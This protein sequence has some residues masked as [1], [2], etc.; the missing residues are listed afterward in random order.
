MSAPPNAGRPADGPESGPTTRGTAEHLLAGL[1]RALRRHP[2]SRVLASATYRLAARIGGVRLGSLESG[3]ALWLDLGDYVQ[4]HIYMW[5]TFEEAATRYLRHHAESSWTFIDVG[6]CEGYYAVLAVALGG[7]GS[8]V[9]AVEPNPGMAARLRDTVRRGGYPIEL[10]EVGCGAAPGV[11]PLTISDLRG[12]IGM[13]SFTQHDRGASTVEVPIATLDD[14]CAARGLRP[15]VVKIDVE[16]FETE[17]LTGFAATL[18]QAP[19]PL[20]LVELAPH[21]AV[22]RAGAGPADVDGLPGAADPLR[23]HQHRAGVGRR[24]L[25]R[26]SRGVPATV[27][28]PR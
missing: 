5:G 9:V 25:G 23:R 21:S 4:R 22:P 12:N 15:D 16:G 7:A 11:L 19:P 6:S 1:T 27:G 3:E 18:R 13:S 20:L 28:S 24:A 14:I 2:D 26:R 8:R 17:V 10:L